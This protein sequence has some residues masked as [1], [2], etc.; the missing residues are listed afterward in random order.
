M[1]C[2]IR[3]SAGIRNPAVEVANT[4]DLAS[5]TG[6]QPVASGPVRNDALIITAGVAGDGDHGE[7]RYARGHHL[8]RVEGVVA[9]E[10]HHSFAI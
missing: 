3:S 6:E 2:G 10:I 7:I 9:V 5:V 4:P 8:G 1:P